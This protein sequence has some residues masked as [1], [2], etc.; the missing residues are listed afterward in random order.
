MVED[1]CLD[2]G[3]NAV[4]VRPLGTRESV[5]QAVRAV[6]LEV[7]PDFIELLSGIAHHFAGAAHIRQFAGDFEQRQLASF[8]LV[9][10]GHLRSLSCLRVVS[11]RH[12]T[13]FHAVRRP[14]TGRADFYGPRP[15]PSVAYVR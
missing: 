2:F 12:Q 15:V 14:R 7:P 9:F 5:D 4:R 6:G 8:Y 10:R 11:Q 1:R 3:R 13:R